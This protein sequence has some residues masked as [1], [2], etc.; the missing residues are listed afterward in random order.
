[1]P[2]NGKKWV[3]KS[4]RHRWPG[5]RERSLG[6]GKPGRRVIRASGCEETLDARILYGLDRLVA[7]AE[8]VL[9]IKLTLEAGTF[10]A[11]EDDESD[12]E[13]EEEPDGE[14]KG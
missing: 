5:E 1:M 14:W 6:E 13:E 9:A 4:S 7:A 12:W 10:A 11:A 3:P 8:E 2:R